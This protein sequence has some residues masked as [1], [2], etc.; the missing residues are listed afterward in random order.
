MH[1]STGRYR[2]GQVRGWL[3][4]LAAGLVRQATV[5][6]SAS[7]INLVSWWRQAGQK[8]AAIIHIGVAMLPAA[9]FFI[10]LAVQNDP[11]AFFFLASSL[12]FGCIAGPVLEPHNVNISRIRSHEIISR[13][14]YGLSLGFATGTGVALSAGL[15]VGFAGGLAGGLTFGLAGLVLGFAAWKPRSGS[16][17]DAAQA[18]GPRDAICGDGRFGLVGG[19]AGGLA[20]GLAGG[21]GKVALRSGSRVDWDSA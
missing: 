6:E 5:N 15:A 20:F 3:T 2:P 8:T 11:I 14:A 21:I 1:H 13:L 10:V 4:E 16:D 12:A 18:I 9:I 7:D 17:L 19:L